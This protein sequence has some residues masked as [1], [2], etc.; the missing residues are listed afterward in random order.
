MLLVLSDK[1]EAWNTKISKKKDNK[2]I[3][4]KAW[5][6]QS[7]VSTLVQFIRAKGV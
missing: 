7:C 1:S 2:L 4:S 5:L 6:I 3:K